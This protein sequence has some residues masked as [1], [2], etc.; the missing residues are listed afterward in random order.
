MS[1][2]K[3]SSNCFETSS[4]DPS[5]V[6]RAFLA[7]LRRF[8]SQNRDIS[9]QDAPSAFAG[10][11]GEADEQTAIS[12]RQAMEDLLDSGAVVVERLDGGSNRLAGL[13]TNARVSGTSH[14]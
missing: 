12:F 4:L 8:E 7:H 10:V 1:P 3:L 5:S 2:A 9:W 11:Y 6:S 14:V 13:N